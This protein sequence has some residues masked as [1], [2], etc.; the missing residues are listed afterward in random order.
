MFDIKKFIITSIILI[1]I[2]SVYLYFIKDYFRNQIETIQGT[3]MKVNII[4]VVLCYIFISIGYNYFIV[5]NRKSILDSFILGLVIYGVYE[6]TNM[7]LFTKWSWK[8]VAIDTIWGG[9]LFG[10]TTSIYKT[11]L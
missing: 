8:T 2:D 11:I 3:S 4:A 10:L 7:A 9:V 5:L 1:L 6:T